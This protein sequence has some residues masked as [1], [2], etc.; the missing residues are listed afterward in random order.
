M[1]PIV[2]IRDPRYSG[3]KA[4]VR[5]QREDTFLSD[6][7][8]ILEATAAQETAY[9]NALAVLTARAVREWQAA[10]DQL[11]SVLEIVD[12]DEESR[13]QINITTTQMRAQLHA[14]LSMVKQLLEEANGMG[15]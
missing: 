8:T 3:S 9:R 12:L 11:E 14:K 2:N 7:P 4:P 15:R 10:T 1:P 5:P 6:V 13:R